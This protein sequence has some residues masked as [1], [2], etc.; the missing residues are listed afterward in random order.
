MSYYS[1]LMKT[2]CLYETLLIDGRNLM[3]ELYYARK[4]NDSELC[5]YLEKRLKICEEDF[6]R[7][8]PNKDFYGAIRELLDCESE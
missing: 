3:N 5:N 2:V 7:M 6:E 8:F 1:E 4:D